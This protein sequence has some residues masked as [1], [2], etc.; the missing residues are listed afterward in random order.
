MS[1]EVSAPGPATRARAAPLLLLTSLYIA[2]GLPYGFFTQALPVLMREHGA[3]LKAISA[4]AFLFL[5]WA[6]KFLWAPLVDHLGTRRGWIVPIQFTAAIGAALLAL[7]DPG[8][9]FL[10]VFAAVFAFNLL[11]A[12]QDVATDGMAV[13][14][15]DVRARGLGNG[16]QVGA[17]RIGM[18]L[19]G[20]LLLWVYAKLGWVAMCIGMSALLALTCVPV[21]LHREAA[22]ATPRKLRPSLPVLASGWLPRLQLPGMLALLLLVCAYKFG[23]AMTG[24][25]VGPMLKD[26]HWA[27]E[28]I[29]I[30]KGALGSIMGLVGAAAGGWLAFRLGRRRALLGC[31]I[32]QALS[33]LLYVAAADAPDDR[34]LVW[35]ACIAEHLFGGMATVALFS[36]MMDAS[37]P[38]HAGT[39][40]SLLACAVVVAQGLAAFTA[41]A[42]GD[43]FGYV[44]VFVTAF[45]LSS[46][47]CLLLIA[48]LDCRLGPARLDE[49]WR[50]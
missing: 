13:R 35:T 24:S 25:L 17:Y 7:V 4:T 42:I 15:L 29:A 50:L 8:R 1:A 14:L 11:A 10:I 21:L 20:G 39:D 38:A 26:A 16:I 44:A 47:G 5:P 27:I 2:Q 48:A 43:A 19:G 31:G 34:P 3:S 6:L 28:E 12:V 46:L 33:L 36:L 18:V 23:D 9:G 40:Y 41:A 30:V 49:V 22:D 37:D 45:V 32:A